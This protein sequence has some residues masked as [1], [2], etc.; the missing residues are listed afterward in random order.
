MKLILAFLLSACV[1]G[2]LAA[3]NIDTFGRNDVLFFQK[4]AAEYQRWLEHTGIGHAV[5]VEKVDLKNRDTELELLLSLATQNPDSA[6]A[7]WHQLQRDFSRASGGRQLEAELFQVFVHMMEIKPQQG[8]VQLY[9]LDRFGNHA[10]CF[11][12]GIWEGNNRIMTR[13]DTCKAEPVFLTIPP[14]YLSKIQK[15]K[16]LTTQKKL[17]STEVFDK[18]LAYA[19]RW[20]QPTC[21]DRYP[22]VTDIE[23]TANRLKFTVSDLCRVVLVSERPSLLCDLI[24]ACGGTCN[25]TR[26]ERLEFD[27]EYLAEENKLRCQVMGKFGSGVYK[28]RKSGWLN[29]EPDFADYLEEFIK[30]FKSDLETALSK[31]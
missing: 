29:M 10:P 6:I 5:S 7:I 17:S 27:I 18:V 26:R 2:A 13:L 28:P 15:G 11:Y 30:K 24:T 20:E 3:Q 4:K 22:K 25:D 23:R 14:V 21:A 8:N 1:A 19:Y 16:V 12:V 9:I 31:P